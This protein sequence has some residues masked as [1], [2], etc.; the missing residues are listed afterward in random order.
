MTK[1]WKRVQQQPVVA[2]LLRAVERFNSRLGGQFAGALTYFSI[3]AGVPILMVGFAALG[4]LLELRPDL[5]AMVRDQAVGLVSSV[6]GTGSPDTAKKIG[7]LIDG[8]LVGHGTIGG[9]GLLAMLYAGTNWVGNL[10]SAIRAQWRPRFDQGEQKR[11]IA[12]EVV[13]NAL[14]L[15][16]L[17]VLVLI[18]FGLAA[19][20]TSLQD[21]IVNAL[22]VEGTALAVLL[23][24]APIVLSVV[25]GWILFMYLYSVFP[26]DPVPWRARAIGALLAAIG[27]GVLQYAAT[28][29][30][31][32][33]A[34]NPAALV[35]GSLIALMLFFNLFA[36]LTLFVAAWI[37]TYDPSTSSADDR[38]VVHDP[39]SPV[40]GPATPP[41][42]LRTRPRGQAK[43]AALPV[44]GEVAWRPGEG[45]DFVPQQVAVRGVRVGMGAGWITGIAAGTG[46]G[47][48]I[49]GIAA[50]IGRRRR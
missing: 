34:R 49:A 23:Q 1:W 25:A 36:Q 40:Q 10:K 38:V 45:Q 43:V 31:G 3:L 35:F 15:V 9:V 16:G 33:F 46:I 21:L 48:V 41:P 17:L 27:L 28:I 2:H 47:A 24:V 6:V 14:T 44:N 18:T 37:A 29:I 22:H 11:N 39:R 13:M 8:A 5:L 20:A 30:F 42:G 32:M 4:Y 7:D 26:Q 50:R 19:A 12:L